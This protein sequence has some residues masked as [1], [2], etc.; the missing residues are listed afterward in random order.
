MNLDLKDIHVNTPMDEPKFLLMKLEHFPQDMIGRYKVMEMV[1]AKGNLNVRVEKVMYELPQAG[2]IANKLLEEK[3]KDFGY[4]QSIVTPGY[5]KYD[6]QDISFRLIGGNFGVKY[7]GKKHAN[8]L[9]EALC[10]F[11]VVNKNEEG[12]QILM[13]YIR[14]GPKNKKVHLSVPG[15]CSEALQ[16]FRHKR[17]KLQDKPH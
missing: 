12:R 7:V 13:Y 10:K 17:G 14:L 3:L 8:H 11:Y 9:L 6:W 1:D 5:W 2:N 4:R 15:Y 16:R